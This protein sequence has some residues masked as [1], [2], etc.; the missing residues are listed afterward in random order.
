M[1]QLVTVTF[2]VNDITGEEKFVDNL[3]GD[4]EF[5]EGEREVTRQITQEEFDLLHENFG[6]RLKIYRYIKN[7]PFNDKFKPPFEVNYKTGLTRRLHHE[8]VINHSGFLEEMNFYA[9]ATYNPAKMGYDYYDRILCV[10]FTYTIDP[11]TQFVVQRIKEVS[12]LQE[13]EE[14]HPDVK[15]MVKLYSLIEMD[16]E[17]IRRRKNVIALLKLDLAR[18]ISWLVSV[19]YPDPATR[20]NSN[21]AAKQIMGPLNIPILNYINGGDN[22]IYYII[23]NADDDFFE[24]MMPE[25]G[26]TVRQFCLDR[27]RDNVSLP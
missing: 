15:T 9:G 3:P 22:S 26:K 27:L 18:F 17:A 24:I 1:S 16:D 2:I 5:Q 11:S 19:Q 6:K 4:Y 14:V 7:V 13:D 20:P 12:Y 21:D 8:P 23:Q 25:E 10:K